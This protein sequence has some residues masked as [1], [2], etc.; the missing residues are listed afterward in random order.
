MDKDVTMIF[1]TCDAY[2]DLWENFFILFKKYWPDFDGEIIFNTESKS[3]SNEGLNI[4]MPKSFRSWDRGARDYIM[5]SNRVLAI[6]SYLYLR[7]F[8]LYHL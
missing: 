1:C 4:V 2:A 8:T 5:H 6:K 7:T 3:Y